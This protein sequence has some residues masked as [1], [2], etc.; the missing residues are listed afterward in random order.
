MGSA[1][2]M[3]LLLDKNI[4]PRLRCQPMT[5]NN[6]PIYN[7]FGMVCGYLCRYSDTMI[8][9]FITLGNPPRGVSF[10]GAL[11]HLYKRTPCFEKIAFDAKLSVISIF[12]RFHFRHAAKVI[13]GEA[14]VL[15]RRE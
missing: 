15:F 10:P 11:I 7:H 1:I 4:G 3:R 13:A 9:N 8:M 5:I 14:T 6:S 12:H 2:A